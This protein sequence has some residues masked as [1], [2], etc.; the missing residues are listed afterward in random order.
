MRPSLFEDR[1]AGLPGAAYPVAGEPAVAYRGHAAVVDR[2]A[3]AHGP[4]S[5]RRGRRP[6]T[7]SVPE[8]KIGAVGQVSVTEFAEKVLRTIERAAGGV[9]SPTARGLRPALLEGE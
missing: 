9:R 3:A 7:V 2:A 4:V 6:L 1:A 5:F 8:L